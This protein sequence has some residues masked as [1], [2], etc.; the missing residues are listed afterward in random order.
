[1]PAS[2]STKSVREE[3]SIVCGTHKGGGLFLIQE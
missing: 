2:T 3:K 1:M